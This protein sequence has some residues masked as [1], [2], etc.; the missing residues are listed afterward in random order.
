MSLTPDNV[1]VM[2][3]NRVAQ[4]DLEAFREATKGTLIERMHME[5][6]EVTAARTVATMPVLGNTQP[7]GLLHGGASVALAET[8]GSFAAAQHAGPDAA[9]VG[10]E[11]SATHHRAVRSGSVTAVATAIHLGRTMATYEIVLT[12]DQDKRVCTARLTCMILAE[13]R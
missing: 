2:T 1:S 11:I 9:V 6:Q 3:D 10:I 13:K 4:P 8:V 5:I 7:A 12:D